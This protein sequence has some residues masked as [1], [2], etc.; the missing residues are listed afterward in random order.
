[1]ALTIDL[2]TKRENQFRK[3]AA[4]NGDSLENFLLKLLKKSSF[5]KDINEI[6]E[7]FTESELLKKVDLDISETEWANYRRLISLRNAECLTEKEHKSL[8]KLGDKIELANAKRLK[9]LFKL[10]QLRN[11]PIEKLMKDLNI[12]PI[13]V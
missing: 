2:P 7:N 1:M 13:E 11:L 6:S 8:I 5:L 10:A 4:R 9:H 12:N 3:E